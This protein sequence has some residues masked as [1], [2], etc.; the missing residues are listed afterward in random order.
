MYTGLALRQE[1]VRVVHTI[2]DLVYLC[3]SDSV[4]MNRVFGGWV[5]QFIYGPGAGGLSGY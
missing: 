1:G 2:Y 4:T 3:G 5:M